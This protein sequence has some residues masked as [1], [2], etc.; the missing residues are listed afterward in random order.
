MLEEF[1]KNFFHTQDK[2]RIFY[3]TNFDPL[4]F[5]SK[6]P[7]LVFNYGLLCSHGHWQ[8]QLQFFIDLGFNLLFHDYRGHFSSSG[9]NKLED[10]NFPTI[11]SDLRQ[12]LQSLKVDNIVMLGHSMGVN[13][14]LEYSRLYPDTLKGTVLISGTVFPPQDIM[15][16]SNIVD[17][18]TPALKWFTA[19]FPDTYESIWKNTYKNPLARFFVRNGGFNMSKIKDDYVQYYMKKISELPKELMLHLL[20]EMKSHSIINDLENISTP[21]LVIGGDKD[22]IIPNYLQKILEKHMPNAELYIVKEGSHVP[23][24]DFPEY[25]N[26]RIQLFLKKIFNL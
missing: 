25:I 13:V 15:F 20:D 3:Q 4:D 16:D 9:S 1:H 18:A 22:K 6:A 14:A 21:A 5:D 12:L 23:Q 8:Y 26:P 17:I 2:I 19:S 10:I 11:C 7:L 24:S